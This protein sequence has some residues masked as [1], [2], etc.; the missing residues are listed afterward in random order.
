MSAQ[1]LHI[2]LY[3]IVAS[4]LLSSC[5]GMRT[6]PQ[7]HDEKDSL[8]ARV[9]SH[10]LYLSDIE[11]FATDAMEAEDSLA[12]LNSYVEQWVRRKTVLEYAENTVSPEL[13]IPKLMEEY[14]SSLLLHNYRQNIIRDK[15]DTMITEA[16]LS[17]FYDVNREQYR[18]AEPIVRGM[19]AVFEAK[20]KGLERFYANWKKDKFVSISTF[21]D[22][23]AIFYLS[24]TT[25]WYSQDEFFSFLPGNKI[26][27]RNM[28]DGKNFQYNSDKREYFVKVV[29][30][31]DTKEY[32]PLEYVKDKMKK[33]ILNTRKNQLL[34]NI[35]EDI[36]EN[37]LEANRVKVYTK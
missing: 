15:L 30:Y 8:L 21:C 36:Y 29:E 23:N 17:N 10:E 20:Q 33:V 6:S 9:G 3:V 2:A 12:V 11:G 5:D 31:V 14:K 25:R 37:A 1:T 18:I 24:D 19:V 13:D 27:S 26:K 32:P 35:E 7:K 34:R 16:Q 28:G 4:M 22:E